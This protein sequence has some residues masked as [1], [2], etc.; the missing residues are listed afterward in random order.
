[1]FVF[2]DLDDTL[3]QTKR[4][5][6]NAIIQATE[7]PNLLTVSYMS[8]EQNALLNMFKKDE[9]NNKYK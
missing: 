2:V 6:S 4:K 7:S 5:N 1:V 3:F 9:D 8:E